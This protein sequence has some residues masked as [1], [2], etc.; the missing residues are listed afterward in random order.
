[1]GININP[2]YHVLIIYKKVEMHK[3]LKVPPNELK[4]LDFTKL[5]SFKRQHTTIKAVIAVKVFV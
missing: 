5:Y 3:F 1:M 4:L 2:A